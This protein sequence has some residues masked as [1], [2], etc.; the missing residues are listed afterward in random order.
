MFYLN[1]PIGALTLFVIALFFD[2][3]A[4]E[5]PENMRLVDWIQKLDP[6]SNVIFVPAI[7]CLLLALQW[8]GS[9]YPWS[10][11]RIIALFVLFGVLI[12]IF[13]FIQVRKGERAIVPPRILKRSIVAGAWFSLCLGS[14]FFIIVY[15][16][17]GFE[18]GP[19]ID[20]C[21]A[22]AAYMVPDDKRGIRLEIRN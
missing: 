19:F 11:G 9:R 22:L 6:V 18:Y 5:R 2:D 7:V 21:F 4:C 13:I 15:F 10:H 3:P 14:S 8:G 20:S 17:S 1:L 12:S 16:V